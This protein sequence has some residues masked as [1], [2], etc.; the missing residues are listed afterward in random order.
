V[1]RCPHASATLAIGLATAGAFAQEAPNTISATQPSPDQWVLRTSARAWLF[2]GGAAAVA[3]DGFVVEERFRLALGITKEFAAEVSLP[4]FQANFDDPTP[5]QS[6]FDP[7]RTGIGDLDLTFKWR[8]WKEDLGPVDTVRLA[9]IAGTEVPTATNDFGSRSFDP[10]AGAAFTGIFGRHAIGAA[11]TWRFT[12]DDTEYP[13]FAGDSLADVLS[14][15]VAHLYR[16]SPAVFPEEHVGAW[17]LTT[18]LLSTYET[19]GDYEVAFTP[20]ILY[21][22]PRWAFEA[23]VSVPIVR[24]LEH[25]P[26]SSISGFIGLRFL[27]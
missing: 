8:V 27:F 19:N 17:Y 18:E 16:I 24:E 20:G 25:R 26:T 15:N 9:I 21:E 3:R 4:L 23:G 1:T 14:L 12:T 10:V 5:Q 6:P 22:G 11:L 2:D 13:L 7:D